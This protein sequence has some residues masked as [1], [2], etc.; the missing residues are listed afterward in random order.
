ML[1]RRELLQRGG[2]LAAGLALP[3]AP[4]FGAGN[5][6]KLILRVKNGL[7]RILGKE[8]SLEHILFGGGFRAPFDHDNCVPSRGDKEINIALIKLAL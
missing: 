4:G 2:A 3:V 6:R 8:Q 7:D 5:L 1:S